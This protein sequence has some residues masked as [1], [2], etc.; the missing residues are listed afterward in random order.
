MEQLRELGVGDR[1]RSLF[2]ELHAYEA[3][4][5]VERKMRKQFRVLQHV[6]KL[7]CLTRKRRFGTAVAS[8]IASTKL[9]YV[10][11]G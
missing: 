11:P 10:E 5:E 8:F 9:L 6:L 1:S 3:G 7:I 4:V 2:A